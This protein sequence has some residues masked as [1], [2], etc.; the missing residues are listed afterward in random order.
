VFPSAGSPDTDSGSSGGSSGAGC[1]LAQMR[2][3]LAAVTGRPM[4]GLRLVL[5]RDT[6]LFDLAIAVRRIRRVD[7]VVIAGQAAR[8]VRGTPS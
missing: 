8:P 1:G 7:G 3:G 6:G 4:A 5:T 2:G